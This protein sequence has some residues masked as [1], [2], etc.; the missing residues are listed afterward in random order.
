ME[1][2]NENRSATFDVTSGDGLDR[3]RSE[4]SLTAVRSTLGGLRLP[5][6]AAGAGVDARSDLEFRLTVLKL[7]PWLGWAA[8]VAVTAG[9]VFGRASHMDLLVVLILTAAAVNAAAMF[10]PWHTLLQA[11]RGRMLL[12]LW[13]ASLIGF[14]ALL[15]ATG[16]VNF[17]FLLFLTVPYIA[18]VQIGTRRRLWLAVAA[19]T[20]VFVAAVE[21]LPAGVTAMRSALVAAAVAAVLVLA[22]AIKRETAARRAALDRAE[23]ERTLAAEANHRIKNNLQTVADLLLLD[24]PP[25]MEGQAFEDSAARIRAIAALHRLLAEQASS[26]VDADALLESIARSASVPVAIDAEPLTFDSTTAQKVGLVANEL[27]TN[28]IRHGAEPINVTFGGRAPTVLRVDDA[29]SRT[30]TQDGLGLTLVR[31][32]AEQGLGGDFRLGARPDGGT[33]AEVAFLLDPR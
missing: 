7:G 6:R 28:A 12:D 32:I 11:M 30:S 5:P 19:A 9:L 4:M 23:L 10:L 18:V 1:P 29:G 13:S 16:G 20:C 17:S 14:V 26:T 31:R 25:G 2:V 22:H 8:L 21:G 3:V 24:R 33:R 27:I 15:V